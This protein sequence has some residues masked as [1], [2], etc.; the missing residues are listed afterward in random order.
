MKREYLQIF[1]IYF[2]LDIMR[3]YLKGS[4]FGRVWFVLRLEK[5]KSS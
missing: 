3:P 2:V 5:L 4:F 1:N